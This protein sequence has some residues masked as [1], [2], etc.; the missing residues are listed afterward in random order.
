MKSVKTKLII[1]FTILILISSISMGVVLIINSTKS[2][3]AQAEESLKLASHEAAQLVNSGIEGQKNV[4]NILSSRVDIESMDW[5]IQAPVLNRLLTQTSFLSFGVADL[6]GILRF[7][8]N[9]TT[10]IS[11]EDYFKDALNGNESTSQF[12]TNPNT[13]KL[14]YRYSTP[15]DRDGNIVGVL[16]GVRDGQGLSDIVSKI[17]YGEK[18]YSYIING[19]GTTIAHRDNSIVEKDTNCIEISKTN[20]DYKSLGL[21]LEE[22][23][24]STNATNEYSYGGN[25]FYIGHSIIPGT[26]WHIVIT[27]DKN[28]VLAA[29]PGMVTTIIVIGSIVLLLSIGATYIIG[30]SIVKPIIRVK[31]DSKKLAHLDITHDVDP[32]LLNQKDEIGVLANSIQ[33]IV[34]NLRGIINEIS[35]SSNNVASSSEELNAISHQSSEALEQ[36]AISVNEVADGAADQAANTEKGSLKAAELGEI[37]ESDQLEMEDVNTEFEKVIR[38]VEDGLLEIENLSKITDESSLS[39]EEIHGVILK[40]N[41]S[42]NRIGQASNVIASIAEQTNLLALN[43]AIEAA[44]AGEAG[45]GF[46]V[47]ADEIR[48]L[49][50]QSSISTRDID[51]VV[52]DLQRNSEDA[53][54]TVERVSSIS[55]EQSISVLNSREK[56]ILISDSMSDSENAIGRLNASSQNVERM[57]D[58]ILDTLQNLAAI[59]EENSAATQEVSAAVEEQA[60]SMEEISSAS[61]GLSILAQDLNDII[62]RFKI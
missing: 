9:S 11:N 15:I 1:Y 53:V 27:A 49:A 46:A 61:E 12:I 24:A 33:S 50:E 56:F 2:L 51:G 17:G 37:I 38:A 26:D 45:R 6:S 14:E 28:E 10:N 47:V 20:P 60:A 39:I 7:H 55:K 52:N 42:S 43:A 58:Q 22:V 29:I 59:A 5:E 4:L 23:L 31:D 54:Q 32:D 35:E 62:V 19:Q 48:K 3:T 34:L 44:R 36:V 18:G 16:I 25:D 13:N 41:E 40:T 21:A 57:K 8:D 30:S